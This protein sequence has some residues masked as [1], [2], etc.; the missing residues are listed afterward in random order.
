LKE[1]LFSLVAKE[2]GELRD[3]RDGQSRLRKMCYQR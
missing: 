3:G 2:S 1:T